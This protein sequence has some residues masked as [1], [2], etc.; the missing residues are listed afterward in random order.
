M[1]G[2]VFATERMSCEVPATS[3]VSWAAVPFR[4]STVYAKSF[5][6]GSKPGRWPVVA[7][8]LVAFDVGEVRGAVGDGP[9]AHGRPPSG[10]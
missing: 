2:V 7:L 9:D 8:T 10:T 3:S 6:R 1:N 4:N 5:M